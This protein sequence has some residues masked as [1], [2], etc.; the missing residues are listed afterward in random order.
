MLRTSGVFW[1]FHRPLRDNVA[2]SDDPKRQCC[3]ESVVLESLLFI[4]KPP[5]HRIQSPNIRMKAHTRMTRCSYPLLALL[6]YSVGGHQFSYL[7]NTPVD[8][9]SKMAAYSLDL[10]T[11]YSNRSRFVDSVYASNQRIFSENWHCIRVKKL[12]AYRNCSR[13]AFLLSAYLIC[14]RWNFKDT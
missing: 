5:R 10:R 6:L 7:L 1:L 9:Y 2:L 8:R 12:S 11:R 13:I 3:R 4:W 14:F